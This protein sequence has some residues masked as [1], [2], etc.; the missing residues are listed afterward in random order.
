M[1]CSRMKPIDT[2][3][4]AL[5]LLGVIRDIAGQPANLTSLLQELFSGPPGESEFLS[6]VRAVTR[7]RFLEMAIL[8]S[9][10]AVAGLGPIEAS[11][12]YRDISRS[13][14]MAALVHTEEAAARLRSY[15]P[16]LLSEGDIER[17]RLTVRT[18]MTREDIGRATE[19]LAEIQRRLGDRLQR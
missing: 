16:H 9:L 14:I 6:L 2:D 19:Y 12:V 1:G 15:Y 4:F 18:G 3:A 11:E 5:D 8:D 17:I 10:A 13:V 7:L